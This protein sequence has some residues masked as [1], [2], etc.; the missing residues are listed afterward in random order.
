M[1]GI[2][3]ELTASTT[4]MKLYPQAG[5]ISCR[6]GLLVRSAQPR[7]VVRYAVHDA[8]V[9]LYVNKL[10]GV[11]L[12]PTRRLALHRTHRVP[13]HVCKNSYFWGTRPGSRRLTIVLRALTASTSFCLA[14]RIIQCHH[15]DS[16]GVVPNPRI[17]VED[18]RRFT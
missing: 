18:K 11:V 7:L 17:G 2:K 6:G 3:Y 10:L 5:T 15:R 13:H 8:P 1:L 4:A 9:P 12:H 14:D 16:T